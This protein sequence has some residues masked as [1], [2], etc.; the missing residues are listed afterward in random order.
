MWVKQREKQIFDL[1]GFV[2]DP[3]I[4]KFDSCRKDDLIFIADHFRIVVNEALSKRKIKVVLCVKLVDMG[5]LVVP[6]EIT[7]PEAVEGEPEVVVSPDVATVDGEDI[8]SEKGVVTEPSPDLKPSRLDSGS[9]DSGD[10]KVSLR[11]RAKVRIARF[12][13]EE[14]ERLRDREERERAHER[15]FQVELKKIEMDGKIRLR[16]LELE[17]EQARLSAVSHSPAAAAAATTPLPSP[18]QGNPPFEITKHIGLVPQFRESEVDAYFGAFE[19]VATALRWP[20]DV[21][22]ILLQCKLHGKAQ[23]IIATLSVQDSMNYDLVKTA[24]LRAYEL[25]PEAYRQ[26]FRQHSKSSSQTFVEFSR[27]K[28]ALFDRWCAANRVTDFKTVRELVLLEEFKRCLPDRIVVHLNEQ[29]VASMSEAAIFADEFVLSHKSVF[30]ATP[31][32]PPSHRKVGYVRNYASQPGQRPSEQAGARQREERVCH[33]CKKVGHLIADCRQRQQKQSQNGSKSVGLIKTEKKVKSV[34]VRP[35]F[36]S[37]YDPFVFDGVVSVSKDKEGQ[38]IRMLRDTGAQQSVILTDVLPLGEQTACGASAVIR[39]VEMGFISAPLH[40]V[41]VKS[42]LV[43]GYFKV[44]VRDELPIDGISF[45]MG[46]DIAGGKVYPVIEVVEKPVVETVEQ[47]DLCVNFPDA[48]PACVI[49]R[50]QSRKVGKDADFSNSI[51]MRALAGDNVLPTAPKVLAQ[52]SG[53]N[54]KGG[55]VTGFVKNHIILPV[56]KESLIKAQ[57]S[58]PTLAKCF[59]AVLSSASNNNQRLM[60]WSLLTQDYNLEIRHKR[61]A[62]NVLADALSRAW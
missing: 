29:R 45:V 2:K 22:S 15:A 13:R 14:R 36:D 1:E 40:T 26:K 62:D 47:D 44:A 37:S 4:G 50:A 28:G 53:V 3:T 12:E 7:Q 21:W 9:S 6:A 46:N 43:T 48:F 42:A 24:I 56:T 55:K 19:R 11:T 59:T 34:D 38:S 27:E 30:N 49:T 51:V 23:D 31:V 33:Y 61:G 39:G 10:S 60:R 20:K 57:K 8:G 18:S 32:S 25:V 52:R 41:Y 58:D 35:G 5:V 17:M 54:I 16:Q